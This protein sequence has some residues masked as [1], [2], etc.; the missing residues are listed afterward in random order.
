MAESTPDIEFAEVLRERYG[1]LTKSG[2]RIAQYILR[3]QDDVAFLSASGLAGRLS[4]SEATTVRFAQALGFRG[5]PEMRAALQRAFSLRASHSARLRGRLDDLRQAGDILERVIA[6]EIDYLTQALHSVDRAAMQHAVDL[7]R[8]RKRVFLFG[9][10]PSAALVTLLEVRLLRFQR[11]VIPLTTTG[12]EVL[13][14]LLLMTKDDLLLATAFFDVN[15]TLTFV[16]DHAWK[17]GCPCILLTDTLASLLGDR[18]D[19]MLVARRGPLSSFHSLT[20]PMTIANTLLLALAQTDEEAFTVY[21][22]RLDDTRRAYAAT[23]Q[24]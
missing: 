8:E 14:R 1:T 9:L 6:S 2:K 19:A 12:R 10:G 4:L 7:L 3:N 5:Y 17:C 20:V 23:V 18:A 15:P 22:D 16:L 11:D 21:L 24:P 13:D